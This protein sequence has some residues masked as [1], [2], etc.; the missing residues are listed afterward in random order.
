MVFDHKF[1]NFT[2]NNSQIH[3]SSINGG[4]KKTLNFSMIDIVVI[5][6]VTGATGVKMPTKEKTLKLF[7]YWISHVSLT[8]AQCNFIKMFDED[9]PRGPTISQRYSDFKAR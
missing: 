2:F 1:N 3:G 4:K 9:V 8:I 5:D 6:F 7:V